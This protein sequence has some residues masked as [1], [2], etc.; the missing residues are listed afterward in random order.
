MSRTVPHLRHV[1]ETCLYVDDMD[2]ACAFYERVSGTG[3]QFSD[4]RISGFRF[5]TTMLLLFKRGAT[6]SPIGTPDGI[7][8]PHDG[9]GPQHF[10]FS[11]A[12]EDLDSWRDHLAEL[13]IAV[14]STV[15]WPR[16]GA[17]SLYFRDPDGHLVELATAGLWGIS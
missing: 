3:P 14:E 9:S 1:L 17:T 7:I 4:E 12:P 10:A 15:R 16:D 6:L 13:G 2:R 8:P 11:I 5:G